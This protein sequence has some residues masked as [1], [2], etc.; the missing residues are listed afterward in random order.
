MPFWDGYALVGAHGRSGD[1]HGHQLA[2][3]FDIVFT[4][5]GT[6]TLLPDIQQ[7]ADVV[8]HFLKPGGQFCIAEFHPS[9]YALDWDTYTH[10]YPYFNQGDAFE[11]TVTA[12][13]A[14]AEA[15]DGVKEYFW[16]HGLGEVMQALIDRGLRIE[17]FRE[18]PY[19]FYN[20][21][22]KLTEVRP[23]QYVPSGITEGNIPM[24]YVLA[25]RMQAR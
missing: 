15:V 8:Q 25:G 12:S 9:W 23:G 6:I 20:C 18:Y 10:I 21:F 14:G 22:P 7:W 4:S 2:G 17:R 1:G 13:Y 16:C 24:M 5:Y 3:Q 11:E 19:S